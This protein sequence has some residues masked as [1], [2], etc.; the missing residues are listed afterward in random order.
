MCPLHYRALQGALNSTTS[1]HNTLE[2]LD[3]FDSQ[4]TLNSEMIMDLHWWSALNKQTVATAVWPPQPVLVVESDASQLGWGAPCMKVSTGGHWSVEEA[5]HHINYV[6]GI[7]GGFSSS[8][9]L[10]KLPRSPIL[11]RMDNISAVT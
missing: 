6:P 11:L 1:E 3:K 5:T 4:I 2:C 7:T 8:H 9:N 10:C